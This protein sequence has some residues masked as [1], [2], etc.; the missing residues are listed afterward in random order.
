[1][2]ML[3]KAASPVADVKGEFT[4]KVGVSADIAPG[5]QVVAYAILPSQGVIAHS[6]DFDTEKCFGYSVSVCLVA[7]TPRRLASR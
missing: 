5:F 7:L 1:M 3:A 2:M 6:L 4:F